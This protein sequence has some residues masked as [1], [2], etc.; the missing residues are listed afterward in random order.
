M[1]V[2]TVDHIWSGPTHCEEP[3]SPREQDQKVS[4]I[5]IFP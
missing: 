1:Q 3:K 5:A 2:E 4:Q